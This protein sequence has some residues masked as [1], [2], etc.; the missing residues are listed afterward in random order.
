MSCL[1]KLKIVITDKQMRKLVVSLIWYDNADNV[2]RSIACHDLD[3]VSLIRI[4]L[5]ISNNTI[6]DVDTFYILK[7]DAIEKSSKI[8]GCSLNMLTLHNF[9][10]ILHVV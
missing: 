9:D 10:F 5:K 6:R 4:W 2:N 7:I 8:I 3:I 1:Y